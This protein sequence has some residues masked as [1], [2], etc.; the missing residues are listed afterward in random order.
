LYLGFL[1]VLAG[2]A[3]LMKNATAFLTLPAFVLYLNRFQIRPE[4]TAL[5]ARFGKTF[6]LYRSRVRRWL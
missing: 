1:M 5:Q 3:V 4:E 2:A 6:D